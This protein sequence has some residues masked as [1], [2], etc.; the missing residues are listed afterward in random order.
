MNAHAEIAIVGSGPAGAQAALQAI[1]EGFSVVLIDYGNDD[2]RTLNLIPDEPFSRIRKNDPEQRAY[3]LGDV[4]AL[5]VGEIQVGA[6]LTP[7]RQFITSDVDRLLPLR[8]E[9]FHPM[10]SLALGGLAAGW[11]AGV[12][13]FEDAELRDAGLPVNEMRAYYETV[14]RDIGVSGDARDDVSPFALQLGHVEPPLEIDTN[15]RAILRTY[16]HR[17]DRMRLSG[18]ALGRQALASIANPYLDMDFYS[19][20]RRSVYRPKYTIE[21]LM[22]SPRFRYI[23]RALVERFADDGDAVTV[24][25]RA[26]D[27]SQHTVRAN[28]LL[29]AANALNTA[30]IALRSLEMSGTR[31]PLLC[32]PYHFIPCINVPMLGRHADDRRHSLGQLFGVYTPAHRA[33]ERVTAAFYSYRSLLAYKIVK[34]LPLPTALGLAAV[35]AMLTSLTIAGVHHPD[36]HA[37]GKYLELRRDG[38]AYVLHA[39]YAPDS[40]ERASIRRDLAGMRRILRELRLVPLTTIDPGYGSSI[41]YAGTLPSAPGRSPLGTDSDGKI[42]GTTNVY[43]ADSSGW[44]FLPAKGLTFTIMA[45]ARRIAANACKS[46]RPQISA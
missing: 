10:Q 6:H 18:F 45:N 36:T 37:P 22:G 30:R 4:D 41:H 5:N 14:A 29:L 26:D 25:Y 38:Q 23:C 32:N 24:Y 27:G 17:R 8:S 34:E 9:S 20:S 11:G 21:R 31:V 33:G 16:E 46:L 40:E 3:L 28:K 42:A 1:D 39:E 7:P 15:A 44:N 12:Y 2:T 13:T 43:A 19:D 35:R